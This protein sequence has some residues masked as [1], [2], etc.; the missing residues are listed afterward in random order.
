M[1]IIPQTRP[2]INLKSNFVKTLLCFQFIIHKFSLIYRKLPQLIELVFLEI[3][4]Y[5][6]ET[7]EKSEESYGAVRR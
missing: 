4:R 5:N 6:K 2:L 3:N 7:R 1:L